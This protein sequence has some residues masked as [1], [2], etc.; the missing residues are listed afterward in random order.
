MRRRV[1]VP[2]VDQSLSD[3]SGRG[4]THKDKR[5]KKVP[6]D[7]PQGRKKDEHKERKKDEFD[8]MLLLFLRKK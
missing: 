8:L 3:S 4:V 7:Q 2:Y 6:G 1:R 5:N